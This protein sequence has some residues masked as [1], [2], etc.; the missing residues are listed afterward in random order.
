[1]AV[2]PFK[3][4]KRKMIRKLFKSNNKGRKSNNLLDF[5]PSLNKNDIIIDCGANVGN[6]IKPIINIGCQIIAFEP[7]P[8]AFN[9]LNQNFI[10]NKNVKCYQKAVSTKDGMSELFLHENSKKDNLYWSTGSSLQSTKN[11]IDKENFVMVKT[12][13]FSNFV[14]SL[15]K[16]I[17]IVKIDI[18]GEEVNVINQ[19][20]DKNLH[21]KISQIIVETHERKIP[22]LNAQLNKLKER[23]RKMKIDNISF[24]W[25]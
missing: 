19:L 10:D 14:L 21:L 7:N 5:N 16:E 25:L 3:K 17:K 18:E 20:L 11:N 1:M 6:V 22:L 2:N 24:N 4:F 13:N 12:I 9:V 23:I 15:N 8:H